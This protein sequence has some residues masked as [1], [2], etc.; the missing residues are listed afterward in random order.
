VSAERRSL[1]FRDVLRVREFW[2]LWL[3]DVQ[4]L[5]GDQLARVALSVLVFDGT[6]SGLLTAGV[7]ALTY[8]PALLGSILLGMLADRMP[9][10]ALLVA[11]DL[12]RAVLLAVMALPAVPL[13][14]MAGLLV[15]A[16]VVGTPWKA[17]ESALVADILEGEGYALGAGLRAATTQGA[18]LLGFAAGGAVVALVGPRTTLG[19][20]AATFV[21][22][23]VLI[24]LTVQH[25]PAVHNREPA[26]HGGARRWFGDLGLVFGDQQLR[27][28]LSL[29]WLAGLFVVPEGLAAPYA[30][31]LG[32]GP[33]T[34]GLLLAAGPAGVLLGSL[35]FVRLLPN[36]ARTALVG[37]LA[38]AAGV[39]LLFCA[40][41][42]DLPGTMVLWAAS[43]VCSA[44]Q[45]QIVVEYVSAVPNRRRGHA[46]GVA[47]A[48]LLAAQGIGLLAGGF[49]A[50]AWT[51]AA[52]VASAGAAGIVLATVLAAGRSR[53][54]R[55]ART[56]KRTV[57]A[58]EPGQPE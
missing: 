38:I 13:G 1:Q 44:Y 27:S 21:L 53:R 40:L 25:R 46:I 30:A 50:Q 8:L 45:V 33:S 47:S 31:D 35:L 55:H 49:L 58:A 7:Y 43:G 42:P 56:T 6:G 19:I 12:V 48:G 4:S 3:A 16:V 32:G 18:Q 41:H 20:D 24:R 11:G 57:T 51:V 15:L 22:S 36:Q 29:A 26:G 17:A 2:W 52:A 23:A 9:R 37:P 34:V 54:M 14:V 5:V 28:L 39:P 10:R